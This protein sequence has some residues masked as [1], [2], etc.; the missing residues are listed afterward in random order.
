MRVKICGITNLEDALAVLEAGADMLGY[1]FY[2]Q[3]ARYIPPAHCAQIQAGLRRREEEIITVGVFVNAPE[4]EIR[5]TMDACGLNLAQ[6]HG[7]E[8][9][10]LLARLGEL[11]FKSIRPRSMA[12]GLDAIRSYPSRESPP[13]I[14]VDGYRP[15]AYGG[16]GK[17]GNWSLAST[18]SRQVSLML[19]GGLKPENVAR[20][21]AQ[22]RPW[23]V[24][25]ASGVEKTPGV[26]DHDKIRA[27][28]HNARAESNGH[29]ESVSA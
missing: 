1:N 8:A 10:D 7:D 20:A 15:G 26:K 19:A 4:E 13:G 3:S 25:V 17:T 18:L 16:T 21:V 28:I 12:E 24:D 11:A 23:G 14:L 9:P 22:V 5:S 2:P 29:L 6:L 27:F